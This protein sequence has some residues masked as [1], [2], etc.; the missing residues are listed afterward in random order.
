MPTATKSDR[1]ARLALAG[2]VLVALSDSDPLSSEVLA[3]RAAPSIGLRDVLG[4]LVASGEV[5]EVYRIDGW[6]G[7][8][9]V[10]FALAG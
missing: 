2:R 4:A 1:L 3:S 9:R 7:D 8:F 5:V 6:T 10:E